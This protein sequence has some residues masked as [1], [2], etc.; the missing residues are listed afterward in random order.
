[1]LDQAERI[2]AEARA[3][4]VGTE[5]LVVAILWQDSF[6]GA[7]AEQHPVEGDGRVS[8]LHHLLALLMLPRGAATRGAAGRGMGGVP[9]Q[10]PA[11]PGDR[12]PL[13]CREQ[14]A[15]L[16]GVRYMFGTSM[17]DPEWS[18]VRIHPGG[19]G[20]DPREV[21]ERLLGPPVLTRA[22][23]TRAE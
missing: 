21:L 6:I 2:A 10:R 7:R 1:M 13:P 16:A 22:D 19:S 3:P 14:A 15:G 4:Y 5:H 23:M 17:D 20:L 18:L 8:S 11:G 12:A 9:G